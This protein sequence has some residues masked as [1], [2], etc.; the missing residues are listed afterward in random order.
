[1]GTKEANYVSRLLRNIG[2][3]ALCISEW[4]YNQ[5]DC[6]LNYQQF[7]NVLTVYE[8]LEQLAKEIGI[9]IKKV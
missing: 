3:I 9:E 2:N 1:M 5:K 4:A 6:P 8:K 7:V